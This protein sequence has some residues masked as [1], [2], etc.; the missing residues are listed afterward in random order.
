MEFGGGRHI[1][2]EMCCSAQ[3][4]E[5]EEKERR[6]RR[7]RKGEMANPEEGEEDDVKIKRE[8]GWEGGRKEWSWEG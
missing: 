6:T 3:E 7:H 5:E 1:L 8:E 2:W 4:K